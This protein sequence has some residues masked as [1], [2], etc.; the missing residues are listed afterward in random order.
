FDPAATAYFLFLLPAAALTVI[1]SS[2]SSAKSNL[3][4]YLSGP[5]ALAI[6][7]SFF[8]RL[9]LSPLQ[10]RSLLLAAVAPVLG[11]AALCYGS[12]FGADEIVFGAG[13]SLA[14]SG[15]FGPN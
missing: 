15:G 14:A 7:V 2:L 4:F 9:R 8:A 13:S 11:A 12:T 10:L 6:G 5:L 3:S 1:G